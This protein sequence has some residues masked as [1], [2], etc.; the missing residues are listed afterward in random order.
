M[1]KEY[2]KVLEDTNYKYKKTNSKYVFSK[3]N[4]EL[5]AKKLKFY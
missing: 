2:N 5:T 3:F 1:L 4:E